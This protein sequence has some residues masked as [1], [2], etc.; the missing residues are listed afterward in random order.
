MDV[1]GALFGDARL[2]D[3]LSGAAGLDARGVVDLVVD[4]VRGF[5]SG[6]DPS[7]DVACVAVRREA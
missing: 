2:M 6:R 3:V 1:S 7:D 5:S 4:A